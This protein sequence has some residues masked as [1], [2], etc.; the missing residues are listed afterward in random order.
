MRSNNTNPKAFATFALPPTLPTSSSLPEGD[1]RII[2][3]VNINYE[4]IT[5]I[6][7]LHE[8][9]RVDLFFSLMSHAIFGASLQISQFEI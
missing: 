2:D 1:N 9:E 8:V 5:P 4:Y 7:I 6:I 3:G